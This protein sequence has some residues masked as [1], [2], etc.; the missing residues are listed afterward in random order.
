MKI[1]TSYFYQIRFFPKN[2]VPLSTAIFDPAWYH[3]FTRADTYQ[4]F[5]KRG[6][7]NGMRIPIFMPG[8]QCEGLCR[9][10]NGCISNPNDCA[11]LRAYRKQLDGLDFA[12]TLQKFSSLGARIAQDQGYPE[13]DFA[14]IVHEAPSNGCSERTVIQQWFKDN[15]YDIKEWS[16]DE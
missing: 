13:V 9:G 3:D 4:F 8:A 1:Y 11:F 12:A 10:M 5:D 14:L 15:G 16:K 2:L 6:V 7:L